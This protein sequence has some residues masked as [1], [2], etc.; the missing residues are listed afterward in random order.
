MINR[1]M[2]FYNYFTF[3]EADAYGQ[4]Q[5]S[6]DIQ[7]SVE[8]CINTISQSIQDNIRYRDA[9]YIGLTLDS[10]IDDTFVIEYEK[11]RLKVLF[12][13]PKGRF[14]QVFLTNL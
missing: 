6:K 4:P 13:N 14:K 2:R 7:G 9:S 1:D 8:M 3:G 10:K 11:E 12:V 5:L